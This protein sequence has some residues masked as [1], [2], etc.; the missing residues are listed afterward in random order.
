M[1][2]DISQFNVHDIPTSIL[3]AQSSRQHSQ[4]RACFKK[5][6]LNAICE[7]EVARHSAFRVAIRSA[8]SR[9]P[10]FAC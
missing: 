1:R 4:I 6:R 9:G 8:A 5:T 10:T 7:P 3:W 2:V